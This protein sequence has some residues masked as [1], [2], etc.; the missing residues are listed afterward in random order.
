MIYRGMQQT[1]ADFINVIF[2]F[3]KF[4]MLLA[5]YAIAI[6][7]RIKGLI[8]G[9]ELVRLMEPTTIAFIGANGI[10][11]I[12]RAV[13]K[14]YDDKADKTPYDDLVEPSDEKEDVK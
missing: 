8:N 2:G 5:V 1:I 13:S 4:L 10:E 6:V 9:D 12:T 3:R 14:H 7:F 11:H